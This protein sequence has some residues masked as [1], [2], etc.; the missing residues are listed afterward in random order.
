MGRRVDVDINDLLR[1]VDLAAGLVQDGLVLAGGV[2]DDGVSFAGSDF[3]RID[4][5]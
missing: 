2:L 3:L 4:R 5:G 1:L